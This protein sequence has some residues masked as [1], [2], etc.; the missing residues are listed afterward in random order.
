MLITF[1]WLHPLALLINSL[2]V[3]VRH[4]CYF[5]AHVSCLNHVKSKVLRWTNSRF[6][7]SK[8]PMFDGQ[9]SPKM[10]MENSI[11]LTPLGGHAKKGAPRS[12][13]LIRQA[14]SQGFF[15]GRQCTSQDGRDLQAWPIS[16]WFL[17]LVRLAYEFQTYYH[18]N[19]VYMYIW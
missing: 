14:P 7:T 12:F 9:K 11:F 4:F 16:G 19:I 6:E 13:M 3:L 18:L 5:N 1:A 17:W 8:I 10:G 15:V 2:L